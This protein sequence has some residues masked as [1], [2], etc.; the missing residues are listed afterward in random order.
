MSIGDNKL[1]Q[2]L[3]IG[4]SR[5]K[6][7]NLDISNE[8]SNLGQLVSGQSGSSA[9]ISVGANVVV[10]GLSGFSTQSVGNFL[11]VSGASNM[12]NN[13][14]FLISSFI[15]SSSVQIRHPL[16]VNDPNNGSLNWIESKPYSLEDDLNYIRS[17][18]ALI[19]GVGYYQPIPEYF[20]C[21]DQNTSIPTN[22]SNIAGKTTDAKSFVI[23]KRFDNVSV[24][25]SSSFTTITDVGNL[26]HADS[27]DITGIPIN[28]GYD[29]GN[30]DGTY[31]YIV[32][33]S[34]GQLFVLS[35]VNAG[36]RIFGITRAGGSSSPNSVEIEF[37]S[38]AL[39]DVLSN[40]VPYIWESGQPNTVTVYYGERQCLYNMDENVFRTILTNGIGG[41]P[42]SG[43]GGDLPNATEVGQILMSIDGY[44]FQRV[45]PVTTDEGWLVNDQGYLLVTED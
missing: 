35:G 15:S 1:N 9:S 29:S 17:D 45:L 28:D 34:A 3:D 33:Q 44:T 42:G 20:R 4:G 21:A 18:R 16:A 19:K 13:G 43:S 12:V 6:Q 30:H 41:S 5:N 24:T 23:N 25:D 26:K 37:R 38:V 8:N 10:S 31:V 40:S 39:G 14:R 11:S 7:S 27:I 32:D 36:N 22:L 2:E